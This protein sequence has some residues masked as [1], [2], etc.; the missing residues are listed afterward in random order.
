MDSI[1][2][3]LP[4]AFSLAGWQLLFS[5]TRALTHCYANNRQ[6]DAKIGNSSGMKR[7]SRDALFALHALVLVGLQER[8]HALMRERERARFLLVTRKHRYSRTERVP[9]E[10]RRREGG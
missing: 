6:R 5:H 3:P 10:Q 7:C 2:L 9:V 8:M 1:C 4:R